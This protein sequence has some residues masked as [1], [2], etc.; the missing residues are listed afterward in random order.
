MA[1]LDIVVGTIADAGKLIMSVIGL[2][3]ALGTFTATLA[4]MS[5][6][7]MYAWFVSGLINGFKAYKTFK[8]LLG[9]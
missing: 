6:L 3:L 7:I 8:G 4:L 5:K 2:S 1:I 9:K